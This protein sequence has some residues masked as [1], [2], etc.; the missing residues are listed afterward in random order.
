MNYITNGKIPVIL[1]YLVNLNE[2]KNLELI[3][4]TLRFTLSDNTL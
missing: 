3:F 1:K 2:M 4:E